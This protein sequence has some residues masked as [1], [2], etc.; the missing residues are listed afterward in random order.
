MLGSARAFLDAVT[1]VLLGRR[2]AHLL[3]FGPDAEVRILC[4]WERLPDMA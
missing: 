2:S 4:L 3:N 1:P